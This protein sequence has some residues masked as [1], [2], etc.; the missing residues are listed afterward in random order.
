MALEAEEL[1]LGSCIVGA[2]DPDVAR[3]EFNLP[4][5]IVPYLFLMVGQ[6]DMP[7]SEMHKERTDLKDTV[8]NGTF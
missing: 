4:K 5:N 8:F 6:T 3:K 7:P 2:Y 1:G